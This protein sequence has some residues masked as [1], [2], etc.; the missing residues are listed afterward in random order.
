MKKAVKGKST[1]VAKIATAIPVV[2]VTTVVE[3]ANAGTLLQAITKASS[4][5]NVDIDK[6]ERLFS[7]HQK[8]VAAEAESAFNAALSR[9]QARIGPIVKNKFNDQTQSH[10][11]NIA[12]V[13]TIVAPIYTEEGLSVSF[14]TDDVPGNPELQRVIAIL[15]HSAGHSRRYHYDIYPDNAGAKGT[16]NKTKVHAGASSNTYARRYLVCMIFN[17]STVDNDG[18]TEKEDRAD[19][20]FLQKLRDAA[21]ESS[22]ALTAAWEAGTK[23]ERMSCAHHIANLLHDAKKL[24]TQ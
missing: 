3:Q 10:Y 24:E 21:L 20:D 14:D 6:M 17:V 13:N 18:N 15:S 2:N 8:M 12:A 11:A 4:D 23:T 5:P 1:A 9:A 22:K 16:I 19:P 7:M